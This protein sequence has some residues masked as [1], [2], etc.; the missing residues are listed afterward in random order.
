M[1]RLALGRS[2]MHW[3]Q[4]RAF[5]GSDIGEQ[6]LSCFASYYQLWS[7]LIKVETTFMADVP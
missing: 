1:R 3:T 6:V 5:G 2:L 7:L 4:S